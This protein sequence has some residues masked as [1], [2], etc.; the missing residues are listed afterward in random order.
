MIFIRFI[1]AAFLLLV[2]VLSSLSSAQAQDPHFS[3]YFANR[4]YINP[5]FAGT[6]VCP[7]INLSYR[8]QW[9]NIGGGFSSA[10][11]SY[12]QY[13]KVLHGGIGAYVLSDI[14]GGGTY[15]NISANFMYSFRVRLGDKTFLSLAAE[16]AYVNRYANW[17]S[18]T[19]P[20][21]FDPLLGL[22]RPTTEEELANTPEDKNY[23]DFKVGAVVYGEN[24]YV[25]LSVGHLS[26]PNDAFMGLQRLPIKYTAHVGGIIHFTKSY[27]QKRSEREITLSPNL[28]FTQQGK[29][30]ELNYGMYLNV[31]PMVMGVWYRQSFSNS[32]ALIVLLGA[33]Y[34][35]VSL[36]Y[37][38][39][40]SLSKLK[41]SGGAHEIS[42]GFKLPCTNKTK[43]NKIQPLPCPSF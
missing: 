13:I 35:G 4:L 16:A 23:A 31:Y 7:R 9:P 12:D 5:A 10:T 18:L 29:M 34:K 28:I 36:A 22:V 20:D 40:I 27:G 14:Q 30:E 37:S 15:R 2:L 17:N 39:D 41:G 3:Q 24:F 11:V 19:F 8:N 38:Y 42:L 32:D 33:E 6:G 21:Q 25:G 43:H 26:R 1:Y